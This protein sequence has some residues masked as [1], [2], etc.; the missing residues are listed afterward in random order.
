MRLEEGNFEVHVNVVYDKGVVL[1]LPHDD[2]ISKL[3]ESLADDKEAMTTA[4]DSYTSLPISA[5]DSFRAVFIRFCN[6]RVVPPDLVT[7]AVLMKDLCDQGKVK[8]AH[9]LFHRMIDRRFSPD[10]L[11]YNFLICGYGKEGKMQEVKSLYREMIQRGLSPDS[12]TCHFLVKGYG[13]V[14]MLL[15]SLN[16]VVE[17]QR[18]GVLIPLELYSY[19]GVALCKKNRPHAVK[20]LLR[21]MVIDGCEPSLEMYNELTQCFYKSDGLIEA[22]SLKAEMIEKGL[23]PDLFSYRIL[24][25]SL[26]KLHRTA[27]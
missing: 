19:L 15:S 10:T 24:I 14:G 9:Q 12:T 17:F 25:S 27:K 23:K 13:K 22:L 1:P 2:W 18:L 7:Y 6:R 8:E 20:S 26:C 21:R 3:G 16:L 4:K 5:R 11:A